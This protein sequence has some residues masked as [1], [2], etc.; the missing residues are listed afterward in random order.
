MD[1][2]E[3]EQGEIPYSKR[4]VKMMFRGKYVDYPLSAKSILM[5]MGILSAIMC[6][7]SFVKSYIGTSISSLFVKKT[8]NENFT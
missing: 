3:G 7:L 2:F 1:L 4:I 8:Q 6:S 5:Q